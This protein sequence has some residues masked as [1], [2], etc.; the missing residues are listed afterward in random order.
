MSQI[1]L[2]RNRRFAPLFWTQFL[3]AFNDN[4][5]KNALVILVTYRA[6]SVSGLEAKGHSE[7]KRDSRWQ[8][9]RSRGPSRL[10]LMGLQSAFFGPAKYSVLPEIV[11]D[12]ELVA[13]NALVETGT[14]VAIL[15]GTISAGVIVG[16]VTNP[17]RG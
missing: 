4:L 1:G 10:F 6:W 15:L 2:M 16:G 13:G 14:F 9:R 17:F 12:E 7:A 8:T 3:G 5:F 11:R